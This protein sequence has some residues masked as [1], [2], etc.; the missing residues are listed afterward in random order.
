MSS[1]LGAGYGTDQAPDPY[2]VMAAAT[3][4]VSWIPVAA[5]P[6]FPTAEQGLSYSVLAYAGDVYGYV[7]ARWFFDS[8]KQKMVWR[9]HGTSASPEDI[10][11]WSYLVKP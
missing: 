6:P 8:R 9:L 7:I 3:K 11:H 4:C 2:Q 1:A 5:P 10:T